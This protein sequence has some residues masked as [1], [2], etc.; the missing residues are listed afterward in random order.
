MKKILLLS[1]ALLVALGAPAAEARVFV[2]VGVGGGYY[3]YSYP[4]SYPYPAYYP[5]YVAP[6]PV[7]YSAPPPSPVVYA[8]PPVQD[9]YYGAPPP[10][11]A[12]PVSAPAPTQ[13]S[14]PTY[15]DRKGR[16]CRQFQSPGSTPAYGTACLQP[17]GNWKT[18]E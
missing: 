15:I 17:D 4:Y 1:A 5:Y 13:T 7:V 16:T 11:G 8:A 6:P 12:T 2:G 10:P 14:S 18:V 3:P 9:S